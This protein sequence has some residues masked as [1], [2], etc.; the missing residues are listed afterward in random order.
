M[1]IKDLIGKIDKNDD[2][3]QG[4]ADLDN[5]AQELVCDCSWNETFEAHMKK[6]WIHSWYCTDQWVGLAA[7]F[8]NDEFVC[9]STQ[10]GRKYDED[11]EWVSQEAANKVRDFIISLSKL[12]QVKLLDLNEEIKPEEW[13]E[14]NVCYSLLKD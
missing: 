2:K 9:V 1:T 11:F 8:F 14:S 13:P 3:C 4:L 6:Y 10:V 7:Y 12:D 5:F